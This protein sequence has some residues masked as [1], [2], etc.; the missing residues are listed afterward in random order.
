MTA[1]LMLG[2]CNLWTRDGH[3][4][5]NKKD[6]PG[7]GDYLG[8]PREKWG[9]ISNDVGIPELRMLGPI[10]CFQD[11]EGHPRPHQFHGTWPSPA[12]DPGWEAQLHVHGQSPDSHLACEHYPAK[13]AEEE[14]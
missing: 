14:N 8:V 13:G 2:F 1:Q 3:P 11:L 6:I 7:L 9:C 5:G 4:L 12:V 10:I